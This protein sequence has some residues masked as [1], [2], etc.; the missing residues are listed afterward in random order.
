MRFI[1]IKRYPLPPSGTELMPVEE[2]GETDLSI[3][4]IDAKMIIKIGDLH[5]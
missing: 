4:E 3:K 2:V 5:D 1:S